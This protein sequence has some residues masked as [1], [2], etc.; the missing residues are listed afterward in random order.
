MPHPTSPPTYPVPPRPPVQPGKKPLHGTKKEAPD[1]SSFLDRLD[2]Q[3]KFT[4]DLPP[5]SRL[6]CKRA[7]SFFQPVTRTVMRLRVPPPP[8]PLDS[9]VEA[10]NPYT[11]S[12]LTFLGSSRECLHCHPVVQFPRDPCT[13]GSRPFIS[14]VFVL[15]SYVRAPG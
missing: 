10:S 7:P 6:G 15:V 1:Q 2:H 8:N 9:E 14:G 5:I 4:F 12:L 13:T 11:W 3:R